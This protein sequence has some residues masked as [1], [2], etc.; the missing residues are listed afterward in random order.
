M[1]GGTLPRAA[2]EAIRLLRF[3]ALRGSVGYREEME[4]PE[5]A[6]GRAVSVRIFGNNDPSIACAKCVDIG[7]IDQHGIR[8]RRNDTW[9]RRIRRSGLFSVQSIVE[10]EQ[11]GLEQRIEVDRGQSEVGAEGVELRMR[12]VQRDASIL[13]VLGRACDR[14]PQAGLEM[15]KDLAGCVAGADLDFAGHRKRVPHEPKNRP[16]LARKRGPLAGIDLK[17]SGRRFQNSLS[18][19]GCFILRRMLAARPDAHGF[20]LENPRLGSRRIPDTVR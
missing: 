5:D 13:P 7:A 15:D 8:F 18:E 2:E 20:C 1:N 3:Q 14:F 17:T 11:G 4:F 10:A 16:Y 12:R 6:T 19:Q 9:Q